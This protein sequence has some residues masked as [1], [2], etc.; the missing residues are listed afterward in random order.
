MKWKEAQKRYDEF[1][2]DMMKRDENQP[3]GRKST[4]LT[5]SELGDEE[6]IPT[7]GK[8]GS[9]PKPGGKDG[10]KEDTTWM[11]NLTTRWSRTE[12]E[13]VLEKLKNVNNDG[14]NIKESLVD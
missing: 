13:L 3:T 14:D 4:D 7:V 8:D 9:Q 5:Q 10:N 2:E 1:D 11:E 12:Y 6:G